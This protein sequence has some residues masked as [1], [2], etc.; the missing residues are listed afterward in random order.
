[1]TFPADIIRQLGPTGHSNDI[2]IAFMERDLT[3]IDGTLFQLVIDHFGA[4]ALH[5]LLD[6]SATHMHAD[7]LLET[8]E[9][10]GNE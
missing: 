8:A 5:H 9:C 7:N 10:A 1:M 4:K 2:L 3:A 6:H